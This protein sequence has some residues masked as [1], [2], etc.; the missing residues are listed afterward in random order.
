[1]MNR[2]R[3]HSVYHTFLS[4]YRNISKSPCAHC[5]LVQSWHN[6]CIKQDALEIVSANTVLNEKIE[7]NQSG[8]F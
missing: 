3:S 8:N 4:N 7:K 5:I 1:M 2:S 6:I